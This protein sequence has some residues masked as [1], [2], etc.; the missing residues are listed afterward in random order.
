MLA[1]D[2]A[3]LRSVYLEALATF[4]GRPVRAADDGQ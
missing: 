4:N 1:S 2:T 3:A